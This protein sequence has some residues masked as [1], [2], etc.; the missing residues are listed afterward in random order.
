MYNIAL[1][2]PRFKYP[3]GDMPMGIAY[4]S[5]E[6]LKIKNV[7]LDVI[8]T[9]F[10]KKSSSKYRS[11][12]QKKKYDLVGFSVMTLMINDAFEMAAEIKT[13]HPETKIIMGGPHPT[14]APEHVLANDYVDAVCIG[15]GEKTIFDLLVS[16][17]KFEDIEGIW[18]KKDGMIVKNPP[19]KPVDNLDELE[20]PNRDVFDTEQYFKSWFQLDSVSPSLRGNN[21][22]AS[23]GCPYKCSYCQPTLSKIFGKKIRKRSPENIVQE[24]LFL[25]NKYK[26]EAFMFLD[27]T[28][29]MD[30]KWV[31][32]ICD[33]MIKKRVDLIWGCNTRANLV[34]WDMFN[35]MK[36]AGLRKINMG[37]ESG[38]QRVLDKIYNKGI[39]IEQIKEAI[40]IFKKLDLKTHGYFMIGAPYETEEDILNTINFAKNLDIDEAT[41]S[42]TT[43]LPYTYLY[44][45]SK[46]YINQDFGSFD[47]YKRPV[48]RGEITLPPKKISFLKRRAFIE[49]YLSKKR[50][51]YTLKSLFSPKTY[52]K[53]KRL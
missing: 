12:L 33:E 22:I 16:D 37:I 40:T 2:F 47:Y 27:D 46:E 24:L 29:T 1:I 34:E 7:H 48:Y 11:I 52:L 6:I 44:E 38:S 23:R 43:P 14:V 50:I 30:K 51:K 26:I 21:I 20:F 3:S 10:M 15:E 18:F 9:T 5:S 36:K 49:F 25:K 13:Y 28:F 4:L 32:A 45:I 39:T 19:R 17:L 42:I 8:D 35:K 53:L 31:S 41:F